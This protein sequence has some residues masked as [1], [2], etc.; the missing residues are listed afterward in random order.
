M[1]STLKTVKKAA[2]IADAFGMGSP[3]TKMSLSA[4]IAGLVQPEVPMENYEFKS[5]EV[6]EIL[7]KLLDD[8]K[9]EKADLDEEEVKKV[10][11]HDGLI[12]EKT[13]LKKS[14]DKE[15][16]D[17]KA[18]KASTAETITQKSGDLSTISATLLDDQEYLKDL[19]AKCEDKSNMWDS[20][21]EV[22]SSELTALTQAIQ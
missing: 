21:T 17:A 15:Y 11:A 2:L 22:R 3:K 12:Q 4:M 6:I 16:E 10:A 13:S 8:F 18:D 19:H 1:K 20:R 7:E 14:K 9:D 5:G